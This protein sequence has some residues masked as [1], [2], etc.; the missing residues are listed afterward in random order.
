[1]KGGLQLS[2]T[3]ST[4]TRRNIRRND[5]GNK[6]LNLDITITVHTANNRKANP[7]IFRKGCIFEDLRRFET[8]VFNQKFSY[9]SSFASES[10]IH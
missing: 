3:K 9:H 1:M 5:F 10:N 8:L 2:K 7:G 6:H 4:S